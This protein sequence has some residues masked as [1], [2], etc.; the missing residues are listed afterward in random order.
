MLELTPGDERLAWVAPQP[1]DRNLGEIRLERFPRPAVEALLGQI[2][3]SANLRSSAGCGVRLASDSPWIE[4]RLARLRH[5]Q[6]FPQAIALEIEHNDGVRAVYGP[7]LRES[8][9][10]IAVRLPTGCERGAPPVA[11]AL[12]LPCV[13]TCAIAG[14]A[15][16]DGSRIEPAPASEPRWLVIGDS[17]AQGFSV[18]SPLDCWVHRLS[19]RLDLPCWNLGIGG[20]KIEPAV[21]RWALSARTWE[22]V[23]IALGSNH[24]WR[25]S[26][27]ATAAD[28]AA[29]LAELTL[30]G[31]HRRVVWILPPWKPCESGLG[32]AE[33]QGVPLGPDTGER[34]RQVREVLRTRLSAY[35]PRLILAEGH[36]PEDLRLLPD[37]LHPA[38]HGSAMIAQRLTSALTG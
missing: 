26:D 7:D 38:A 36:V 24:C 12:W 9:G 18:Q 22:V 17:L 27:A 10:E 32:P 14:I 16:A 4:L 3:P 8:Q 23:T 1:V 5:H 20:V 6:P 19:R 37:G 25:E 21:F 34:V 29:E 30:A 35:A 31:A 15:L 2:G 11:L 28:R 13:S 33:F